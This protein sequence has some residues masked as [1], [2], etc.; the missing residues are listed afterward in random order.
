[1]SKTNLITPP[2]MRKIHVLKS[3]N[4]FSDDELHDLVFAWTEKKSLRDLS[5][6][7]AITVCD[8]LQASLNTPTVKNTMQLMP[9]P[10]NEW[11]Q[12]P[13][14]ISLPQFKCIKGKQSALKITDDGLDKF[15]M[16]TVKIY[17]DIT[18]LTSRE[19]SSVINGLVQ[20]EKTKN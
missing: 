9:A 4:K 20:L 15:I 3:Q 1:M 6:S 19:A 12:K 14:G 13:G 7:Q 11:K 2:L 16:H 17:K 8:N 18:D 5:V 10:A